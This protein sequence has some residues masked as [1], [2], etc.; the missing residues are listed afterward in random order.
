VARLSLDD[1]Q[2]DYAT[3]VGGTDYDLT[4]GFTIDPAGRA[5]ITGWT[6]SANFPTTSGA[7]DT[8]LSNDL[9]DVFVARLNASGSDLEYGTYLG[10][11]DTD[12]ALTIAADDG[13]HAFVAGETYSVNFPTTPGAFDTEF[14]LILDGFVVRLNADGS[15]LDYATFLGGDEWD[16]PRA[17]AVDDTG[18]AVV[19]GDTLSFD[20]PTSQYGFDT[21]Y[22]GSRDGFLVRINSDGSG[23][24]YGT[25][26]G[27]ASRDRALAVALGDVHEAY[28]A[29]W[30]DSTD[31]PTVPWA[32]DSSLSDT[33]GA[34]V[35]HLEAD[36]VAAPPTKNLYLPM[37]V[38]Q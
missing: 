8:S 15:A 25:F 32:F 9:G 21:S 38:R 6:D 34:W 24:A 10:G 37:I 2:F 29:G 3:L 20:F 35:A 33:T 5:Y 11:I 30:T 4:S 26:L 7:F 12:E 27:G 31:F 1:S 23:L 17:I 13:G 18:Q 28:V 16:T 19:V 22:N 14:E 36:N